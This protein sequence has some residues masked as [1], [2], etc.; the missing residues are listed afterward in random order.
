MAG[1][2]AEEI[3]GLER[4]VASIVNPRDPA[5][6]PKRLG[7]CPAVLDAGDTVCG[8]V[9]LLRPGQSSVQCT[10]CGSA[11]SPDRWLALARA[12]Q[13]AAA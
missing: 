2:F 4:D 11:W 5:E 12:Q 3:R 1:A 9:L 10:W 7:L 8:A 13:D 6:R